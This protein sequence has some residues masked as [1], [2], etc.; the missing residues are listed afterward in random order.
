MSNKTK[1]NKA[2]CHTCIYRGG[3]SGM[4]ANQLICNYAAITG[5]TCLR[6]GDKGDAVDIRGNDGE[7]CR[8]Y[9]RGRARRGQEKWTC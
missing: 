9:E 7:N 1:F 8:I 5:K 4:K 2:K 6:R 3:T